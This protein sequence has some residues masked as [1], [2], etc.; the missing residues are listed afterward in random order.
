MSGLSQRR[1]TARSRR[2][3]PGVEVRELVT[4]ETLARLSGMLRSIEIGKADATEH[5]EAE[6]RPR[7]AQTYLSFLSERRRAVT[8]PSQDWK[9]SMNSCSSNA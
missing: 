8:N 4:L 5:C 6:P 1:V 7:V 9:S 3:E 2:T